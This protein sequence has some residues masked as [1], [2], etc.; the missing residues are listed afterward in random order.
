MMDK[1]HIQWWQGAVGTS[2][3]ARL[4]AVID[5][6]ET[7][8]F[9]IPSAATLAKLDA[10]AVDAES[11]ILE[12]D[13][14]YVFRMNDTDG[15]NFSR[16][17]WKTP[18]SNLI[19]VVSGA[20]YGTGGYTGDD[21]ADYLN[22]NW[23]PSDGVK[24]LQDDCSVVCG[25]T[26]AITSGRMAFGIFDTGGTATR[27]RL[28][29]SGGLWRAGINDAG[30]VAEAGTGSEEWGGIFRTSSTATGIIIDGT[31]SS[32]TATSTARSDIN[33]YILAQNANGAAGSFSALT[34]GFFAAGSAAMRTGLKAKWDTYVASL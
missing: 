8:V 5:E 10:Y 32:E 30:E 27:L 29:H 12:S 33:M 11:N 16:I 15:A 28:Y 3:S 25:K 9:T 21:T 23:L 34:M 14:F 24:L 1:K 7:Q 18:T 22:T 4:Q 17:N 6:A 2:Y 31:E 26:G 13:V 20:A 19:T